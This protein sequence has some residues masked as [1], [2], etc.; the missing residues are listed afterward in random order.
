MIIR[1]RFHR[2]FRPR[3]KTMVGGDKPLCIA[4]AG[5]G[6]VGAGTIRMLAD[7]AGLSVSNVA[8]RSM[9]SLFPRGTAMPTVV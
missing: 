2:E 8:A 5:L 9:S 4:V 3:F 1:L 7:H 6:T